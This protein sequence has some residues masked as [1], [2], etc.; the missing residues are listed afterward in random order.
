MRE[1]MLSQHS[2]RGQHLVA[3]EALVPRG[4]RA[5]VRTRMRLQLCAAARALPA[6]RALQRHH[7]V[8]ATAL[9]PCR[10]GGAV[11]HG[12]ARGAR[13]VGTLGRVVVV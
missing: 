6:V 2:S 7:A 11:S 9:F 1:L 8:L 12:R 13:A 10:G 4:R 5:G 3:D